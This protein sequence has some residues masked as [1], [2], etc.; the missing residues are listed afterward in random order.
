MRGGGGVAPAPFMDAPPLKRGRRV[1]H[2]KHTLSKPS[3][4]ALSM[5]NGVTV[6]ET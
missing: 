5:N 4:I 6:G 2:V 3:V 1:S